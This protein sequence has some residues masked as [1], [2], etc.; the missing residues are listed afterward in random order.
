MMTLYRLIDFVFWVLDLA[1][2]LRVLFSWINPDPYNTLV[3]WV[4][5]LTE[6]IL[7]PLRRVIPPL[8]GLDITPMVALLILQLVHRLILSVLS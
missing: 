3:R 1:V 6:P 7:A 8:G 5:Q 2:L 4:Y